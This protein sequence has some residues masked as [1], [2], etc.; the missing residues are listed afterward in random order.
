M[1]WTCKQF[2]AVVKKTVKTMKVFARVK[3]YKYKCSIISIY[4]DAHRGPGGEGGRVRVNIGP[5]PRQISKHL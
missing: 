1:V 4:I 3:F 2:R 5:S